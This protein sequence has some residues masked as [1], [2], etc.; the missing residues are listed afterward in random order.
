MTSEHIRR[1]AG[2]VAPSGSDA[3]IDEDVFEHDG[4][5]C[6]WRPIQTG[7]QNS[8]SFSLMEVVETESNAKR[9]DPL[10]N[11]PR[12]KDLGHLTQDLIEER[13]G[14]LTPLSVVVPD[15]GGV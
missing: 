2:L 3:F 8:H 7:V 1:L 4:F 9:I 13:P 12:H 15:Q 6:F 11:H 10:K 14:V 5:E